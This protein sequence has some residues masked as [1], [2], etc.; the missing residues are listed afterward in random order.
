M[1]KDSHNAFHGRKNICLM[2]F[3]CYIKQVIEKIRKC[4][5]KNDLHILGKDVVLAT[6]IEN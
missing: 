1:L 5:L 2:F 3:G 4:A 6:C